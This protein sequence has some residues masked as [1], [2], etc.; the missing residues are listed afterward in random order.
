MRIEAVGDEVVIWAGPL[1][2]QQE[3]GL[4]DVLAVQRVFEEMSR[5]R[6]LHNQSLEIFDHDR[7]LRVLV[8]EVGEVARAIDDIDKAEDRRREG[9]RTQSTAWLEGARHAVGDART[10]LIVE[11]VQVAATAVRWIAAELDKEPTP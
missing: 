5:A 3:S 11:L 10:H 7:R 2:E 6:E 1:T 8:E 9:A 4:R